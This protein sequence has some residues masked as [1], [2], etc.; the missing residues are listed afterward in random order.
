MPGNDSIR[1]LRE[2]HYNATVSS[3]RFV[4]DEL[5]IV[6]VVPDGGPL[7]YEAGQNTVIGVGY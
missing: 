6:D 7:E 4:H 2:A 1:V 3:A 5:L